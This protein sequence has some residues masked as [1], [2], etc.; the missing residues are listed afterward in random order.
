MGKSWQPWKP[1]IEK[2]NTTIAKKGNFFQ[3][4]KFYDLYNNFK[5]DQIDISIVRHI[6]ANY[7][8]MKD[9][10]GVVNQ[11]FYERLI[12]KKT[13]SREEDLEL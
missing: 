10:K 11:K 1:K 2:I 12:E 6:I 4:N 9:I 3:M 8:S 5:K 7:L 13:L